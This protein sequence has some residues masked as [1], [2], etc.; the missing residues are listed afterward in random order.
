MS[1][2]RGRRHNPRPTRVD[3]QRLRPTYGDSDFVTLVHIE[4]RETIHLDTR[5]QA[6]LVVLTHLLAGGLAP[7]Q[8]AAVLGLSTRQAGRLVCRF[9]DDGARA[10]VHGNRGRAPGNRT[11]DAVRHR[12]VELARTELA[13]LNPVRLAETL[14]EKGHAELAVSP[15]TIRRDLAVVTTEVVDDLQG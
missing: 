3:G 12:L 7:A 9:R 6:R 15:R 8:A 14:A 10:L 4:T 1:T 11:G 13:G 5:A 2:T